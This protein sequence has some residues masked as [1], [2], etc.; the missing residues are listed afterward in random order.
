MVGGGPAVNTGR[1]L[2]P[3][4]VVPKHYD[5]TLEPDFKKLTFDGTV[6]ID[7]DCVE[8]S[9]SIS[10]NTREIDLHNVKVTSN[11]KEVR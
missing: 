7:L 8:D 9:N 1:E 11:G 6:V 3:A 5:I 10:L 2:L 4:N